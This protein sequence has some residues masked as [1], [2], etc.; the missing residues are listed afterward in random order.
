MRNESA[1]PGM[2]R[3]A[4]ALVSPQPNIGFVLATKRSSAALLATADVMIRQISHDRY[5]AEP[6]MALS[7]EVALRARGPRT[8]RLPNYSVRIIPGEGPNYEWPI[9][10]LVHGQDTA[11]V[12]WPGERPEIQFA[13]P[14]SIMH[15]MHLH[16]HRFQIVDNRAVRSQG[17]ILDIM[18]LLPHSPA[19]VHI[20]LY[21]PKCQYLNCYYL[22]RI[23]AGIMAARWV[24]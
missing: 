10:G 6:Q 22:H 16:E 15:F 17:L 2:L 5:L 21:Q 24:T 7:F 1:R 19:A 8:R 18:I 11:I 12:A 9:N 20:E 13:T 23:A 4:V 14:I 3:G